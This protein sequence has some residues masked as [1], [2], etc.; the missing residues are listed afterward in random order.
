MGKEWTPQQEAIFAWFKRSEQKALLV[1]ARAGTG[2]TSTIVEALHHAPEARGGS[3]L[4]CAFNKRIQEELQARAPRGVEVKTL[5][6]LGFTA[7]RNNWGRCRP[8]EKR[9]RAI[10]QELCGRF[11]PSAVINSVAKLASLGKLTLTTD[12]EGMER[13]ADAFDQGPTE[14]LEEDGWTIRRYAALALA[15]MDAA[16][17]QSDVID[18]DDMLWVPAKRSLRPP[19]FDLVVVDEAQDLGAAQLALARSALR[20]GGRIV[21]VGDP[22]QAIYSFMGADSRAMGRMRDELA[23][24]E[25]PLTV[26]FRCPREV[27][28]VAQHFVPDYEAAASAPV[29][30]V[31][32]A[33][34]KDLVGAVRPSD[35]VLSRTNAGA[36]SACMAMLRAGVRAQVLGRDIGTGL[37]KLVDQL[38]NGGTLIAFLTRLREWA[39]EERNKA[40]VLDRPQHAERVADQE[41]T[42]GVLAEGLTTVASLKARVDELFTDA[43]GVGRVVCSTVHKAKG[44]ESEVVW[45]MTATFKRDGREE[46]NIRYVAAT[47]AR[48]VLNL[49]VGAAGET[50]IGFEDAA[51]AP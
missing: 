7:V 30:E 25:L 11:A 31:S 13:L 9:G 46:D 40:E 18:F 51:R 49:V 45:V 12:Q 48:S 16:A 1:S 22:F 35:F 17:R 36:A 33:A 29:G 50:D 19:Q 6:S 32:W 20:P 5:H 28:R 38:D 47:R 8:D 4:L 3:V 27:V 21:V 14:S 10:A 39:Y 24:V 43:T 37:K 23:A 44:L 2:K 34:M 42:L 41:E 15:A 26:T